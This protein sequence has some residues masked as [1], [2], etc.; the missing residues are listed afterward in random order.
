MH[1]MASNLAVWVSVIADETTH[2]L[3]IK[4]INA[5]NKEENGKMGY[6]DYYGGNY[7]KLVENIETHCNSSSLLLDY[8][9]KSAYNDTNGKY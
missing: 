6:G 7:T 5:H 2:A 9:G 3:H 4:A 1:V 8:F